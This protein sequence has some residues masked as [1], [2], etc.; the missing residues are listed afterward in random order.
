MSGAFP[1]AAPLAVSAT[2]GAGAPGV[3]VFT[4]PTDPHGLWPTP[5]EAT[6]T[7][8]RWAS[9][10]M[11]MGEGLT[12]RTNW[13]GWRAID[14]INGGIYTWTAGVTMGNAMTWAGAQVFNNG[15]T[16][17]GIL[18]TAFN[19]NINV[20]GTLY[21]QPGGGGT[22]SAFS[23]SQIDIWTPVF[24]IHTGITLNIGCA[25]NRTGADLPSGAGAYRALR[26]VAGPSTSSTITAE[27]Q[28]V[29]VIPATLN[30][31]I[32]YTLDTPPADVELT[33]ISNGYLSGGSVAVLFGGAAIY[34]T[35]GTNAV[36]GAGPASM[37]QVVKLVFDTAL[38]KWFQVSN[39]T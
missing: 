20:N 16:F 39:Q 2:T 7:D 30:T 12:H 32:V 36:F 19:S 25:I 11:Q 33:I 3:L 6:G 23:G 8:P 34:P 28:D 22:A 4:G 38:A 27:A 13:L 17:N 15:V 29:L 26:R 14:W 10:L 37:P 35:T 31:N 5:S 1:G 21:L 24:N 9:Y 18:A